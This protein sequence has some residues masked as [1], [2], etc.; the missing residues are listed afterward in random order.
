MKGSIQKRIGKDGKPSYMARV[1][2]S[3]DRPGKRKQRAKTFATKK[4]AE[5]ALAKWLVE[6]ERGTA[7]EPSRLTV[8]ELAQKWLDT[9][10][11]HKVKPTTLE[12]YEATLRVHALPALGAIP[13]QKLTPTIVQQ[14]YSDKL[15]AGASPRTVQ[16]C[17]LRLSQ[18]LA[19]GVRWD[20][21]PRNVCAVTE[22]PRV[23]YKPGKTWTADDAQRFLAASDA[24]TYHPL[25]LVALTTGLRRGELLGVRWQDLDL[26][27]RTLRVAQTVT[28]LKGA[29]HIQ[30]PKSASALRTVTLPPE[31]VAA[32]S[33][34]RVRQLE[35]RLL[36]GG[37]WQDHD[38][39]FCT[40]EGKPINPPNIARNYGKIIDAAGVP[41]I[42]LH[43][44]RHT[45]ATLLLTN[46]LPVKVVSERLG[47]AKTSITMDTYA[48]VLPGMQEAAADATSA[49][50][51]GQQGVNTGRAVNNP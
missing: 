27:K 41:K 32:L 28:V 46:G 8:A 10:A 1:E 5:S 6:I 24:D 33:A 29:P 9:V 25:W 38:L 42:R 3:G 48:H 35:R 14:F 11:A 20:L 49:L 43:D 23:T 37:A 44:L 21:L 22:P 45:H 31:T 39:V 40:G 12:D 47:H 2:M 34:H 17:H 16:L 15:S 7:V 30:T 19:Q 50:L 18:V 4:E 13:V 36:A 26:N 51:F